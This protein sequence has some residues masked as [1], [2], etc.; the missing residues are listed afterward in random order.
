LLFDEPGTGLD[1][2]S[3]AWLT[4]Q[5]RKLRDSG[6]TILMSLHGESETARIATRAIRL[7]T[8]SVVADTRR[9]A[10]FHSIFSAPG[11]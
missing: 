5:L 8:G 10:L 7:E 1:K 4:E 3:S 9:C 11:C 6:C 2:E